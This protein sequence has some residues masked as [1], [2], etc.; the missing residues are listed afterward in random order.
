MQRR[1]NA[2]YMIYGCDDAELLDYRELAD[3]P[4]LGDVYRAM[5]S[6]ELTKAP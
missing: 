2:L 5:Y 1:I 6:D 3:D 4:S